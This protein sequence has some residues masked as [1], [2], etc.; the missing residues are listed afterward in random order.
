MYRFFSFL[1]TVCTLGI[2][3]GALLAVVLFVHYG[4]D[5]PDYKQLAKY[6]PA[7]TTRV[8]AA[9]GR[10]MEEYAQ[11]KRLFVPITAIPK[12]LSNAFIAA[13]DQNFYHH[14]GIDVSSIFRAAIQNLI[15][16]GRH[17]P[18]V[19]GST[20]TQQVVKNFLLTNEQS[21]SRKVKEAILAF[22][23]TQAFSKDRILELYLNE[24]YLG[25][26]SYGVAA[27]ALNYFDKSIDELSIEEAAMLAALPK[28]PSSLD[29]TKNPER[30]KARRDWVISRMAEEGYI[31]DAEAL[32]A[33]A[34]PI[35]IRHRNETEVVHSG[36][37]SEAV[38]QELVSMYGDERVYKGGLT[39]YSSIDAT[40]QEYADQA[41][42]AGLIAYDHRHGYRGP[43]SHLSSLENWQK[44]LAN[45]AV[46]QAG[47]AVGWHLAVV[48]KLDAAQASIGL[49]DGSEG[50]IPLKEL[51]WARRFLSRD[52]IG[53]KITKP[54][55]VLKRG[56]VV[57]VRL[58]DAKNQTYA[59]EQ[60]PEANGGLVAMDPHTGKVLAMSG[61]FYFGQNSQFNRATQADRQPGSSIK[62]FV[63]SAA[64]S[65]G[66]TPASIIVDEEIQLDQGEDQLEWRPKNYTGKYYGPT[67]LRVGVEDSRNAMTVRLAQLVGIGPILNMV[68]RLNVLNNP[69]RNFSLVLGAEETTLLKLTRG[70]AIIDNGG[71]E[72]KTSLI[73]RVQDSS[74]NTIFKQDNRECEG[75]SLLNTNVD[76]SADGDKGDVVATESEDDASTGDVATVAPLDYTQDPPMVIDTRKQLMD[77]IVAYQMTSILEGVIQRGTGRRARVLHRTLGGK[78]G[79]TDDSVDNWFMGFSPDLVTGVYMGFDNPSSL[80]R[81]E[82]GAS[83]ALPVWI[84]FMR[85][86]LKDKPD[87]PFRRPAGIKLVKIDARNG[88]LPTPQTPKRDIIFEAFRDGTEPTATSGT[89]IPADNNG[90]DAATGAGGIY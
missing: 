22:R 33:K 54:S 84:D 27:A 20:I 42:R 30:A 43:V 12:R 76:I 52:A 38:R 77:P 10:L 31:T 78:T 86:A 18:L 88:Q 39:V 90:G 26:H 7:T 72:I 82:T 49:A 2:L 16:L 29:P 8:Y 4:Q 41:L 47:D 60:V 80:G 70:Y 51:Q 5:L 67:T 65:H 62:P 85:N 35:K 83:V 63:Y 50:S 34:M 59:L 25:N 69:Q 32:M 13:E 17:H 3:A 45:V 9:D 64:L 56:D 6:N 81:H 15:N 74:G 23:I 53:G 46:P 55:D 79:T 48:R 11:E 36:Y 19:G 61:G 87:V 40:L 89:E 28:A 57:L 75:C 14:P 44:D 68:K 58:K 71:K 1:I 37:F 73:D 21:L 66:F 24:I